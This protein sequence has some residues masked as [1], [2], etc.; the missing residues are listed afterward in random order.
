MTPPPPP[1]PKWGKNVK[2]M[3]F[4]KNLLLHSGACF[5]QNKFVVMMT[6]EGSTQI[7]NFMTPGSAKAG[8]DFLPVSIIGFF[9]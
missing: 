9:Y 7:V 2:L 3:Y 5:R 8:V 1:H 6:E 4:L